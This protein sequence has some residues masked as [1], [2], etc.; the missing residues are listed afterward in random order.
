MSMPMYSIVQIPGKGTGW[1]ATQDDS[2]STTILREPPLI[3]FAKNDTEEMMNAKLDN[4]LRKRDWH[5]TP[6][7]IAIP[8]IPIMAK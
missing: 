6:F 1:R 8:L 7:T 3:R 2:S 4:S 5:S